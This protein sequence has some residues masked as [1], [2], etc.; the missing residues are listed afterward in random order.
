MYWLVTSLLAVQLRSRIRERLGVKLSVHAVLE[1]PTLGAMTRHLMDR[2]QPSAPSI[3]VGTIV[4]ATPA[5]PAASAASVVSA[6]SIA[7]AAPAVAA[8][9]VVSAAPVAPTSPP[10]PSPLVIPLHLNAAPV[11]TIFLTQPM[12]GTVYT[13]R[14]LARYLGQNL[15]VYGLRASGMEPDEPIFTDVAQIAERYLQAMRL[16]Q[17]RGPYLVGGYS[18]GGVIAY[19]LA[20]QLSAAGETVSA[21]VMLD[22]VALAQSRLAAALTSDDVQRLF[23]PLE[24]LDPAAF[25]AFRT[26]LVQDSSFRRIILATNRAIALYEPHPTE[27]PMIYLRAK[28]RD[29]VL[30]HHPE[31]GWVPLANNRFELKQVA[32]NHLNLIAEPHVKTLAAALWRSLRSLLS[33]G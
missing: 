33:D 12:G 20:Q 16:V 9:P 10:E 19:E 23:A 2:G 22:T 7:S 4:I 17:P 1:Y 6:A 15:S 11:A 28:E 21:L 13:Y 8:A 3:P 29:D 18:S 14:D 27:V 30:D 32:G 24:R 25:H 26:A 31:L 5:A